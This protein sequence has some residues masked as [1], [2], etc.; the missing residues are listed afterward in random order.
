MLATLNVYSSQWQQIRKNMFETV[1]HCCG[2]P[3][4][5]MIHGL[6]ICQGP[7]LV[8]SLR[9]SHERLPEDKHYLSIYNF[10]IN[11]C[12]S[13]FIHRS[14]YVYRGPNLS[15]H[16]R[17]TRSSRSAEAHR[18]GNLCHRTWWPQ[19]PGPARW[20]PIVISCL[21]MPLTRLIYLS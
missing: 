16:V 5:P 11:H 4:N 6:L 17:I 18:S 8:H 9:P 3:G 14:F 1:Y 13:L 19:P 20:C 21:M 15:R 7:N 2:K 10:T 12:Q